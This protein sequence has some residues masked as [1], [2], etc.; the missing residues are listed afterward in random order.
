VHDALSGLFSGISEPELEHYVIKAALQRTEQVHT[1]YARS[2]ERGGHVA[3]ELAFHHAIY[4]LCLLL[5]PQ[6][7]G[8][9]RGSTA[10][11]FKGTSGRETLV[12]LQE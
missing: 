4:V 5:F 12:A 3:A 7:N 8:V 11:L 1:W 9:I 10:A 6:V 2:V